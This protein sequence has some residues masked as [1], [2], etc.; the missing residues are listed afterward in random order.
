MAAQIGGHRRGRLEQIGKQIPIGL[1]QRVVGIEDVEVHRAV[2]GVDGGFHRIADVVELADAFHADF[3]RVRMDIGGH[4]AIDDPNQAAGV[5]EH[6]V[7][8]GVPGQE[9]GQRAEARA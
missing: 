4:V 8:I 5:G 3:G 2:V 6:Q 1:E 9:I 7:G